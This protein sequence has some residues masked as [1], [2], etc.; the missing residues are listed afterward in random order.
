[1][2]SFILMGAFIGVG[3]ASGKELVTFF[4]RYGNVSIFLSIIAGLLLGLMVFLKLK[5][6][7][8]FTKI[9]KVFNGFFLCCSFIVVSAMLAGIIDI[10]NNFGSGNY[11]LSVVLITLCVILVSIG[12][13]SVEKVNKIF[14]PAIIL[15]IIFM[16]VQFNFVDSNKCVLNLND[17]IFEAVGFML[18]Y[19]GMNILTI[20]P[21]LD[22]VKYKLTSKKE[23]K[24]CGICFSVFITLLLGMCVAMLVKS[25]NFDNSMPLL[26]I[27]FNLSNAMGNFYKILIVMGLITTLISSAIVLKEKIMKGF[28]IKSNLMATFIIFIAGFSV[29]LIGF[30]SI[31]TLIYPLIGVM[32]VAFLIYSIIKCF[33]R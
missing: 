6:N 10:D 22:L 30:T 1:M 2:V 20:S 3:F 23:R 32:G 4:A 24:V 8:K 19:V 26:F 27:A 18:L 21:V 31:I 17:N 15:S 14:I 33:K 25:Q 29:S 28:N 5:T 11:I 7:E 12:V 13:K 9:D 16:L